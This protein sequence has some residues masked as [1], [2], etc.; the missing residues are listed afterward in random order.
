MNR[1]SPES[2]EQQHIIEVPRSRKIETKSENPRVKKRSCTSHSRC[3]P[4]SVV[5]RITFLAQLNAQETNSDMTSI[6]LT[7]TVVSA[8]DLMS[9]DINGKSDPYVKVLH[10]VE[11][12]PQEIFRTNKIKATLNPNWLEKAVDKSSLTHT[13]SITEQSKLIFRLMDWDKIGKHDPL[14]PGGM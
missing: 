3:K 7:F 10:V 12:I 4:I 2:P 13:I 6:A 5:D 9:A 8:R 14:N 1:S 11:D